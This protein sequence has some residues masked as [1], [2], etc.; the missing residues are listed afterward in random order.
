MKSVVKSA[1]EVLARKRSKTIRGNLRHRRAPHGYKNKEAHIRKEGTSSFRR[2]Y[3]MFKQF[4]Q[5]DYSSDQAVYSKET[6]PGLTHSLPSEPSF[7][8]SACHFNY[9][10]HI[11][12]LYCH[13]SST[14]REKGIPCC[15]KLLLSTEGTSGH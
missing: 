8:T 9:S 7:A 4:K 11:P 12:L 5:T 3:T 6:K 14:V 10:H 15:E 13:S 1:V 2:R